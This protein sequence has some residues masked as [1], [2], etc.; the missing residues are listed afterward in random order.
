MR[1]DRADILLVEDSASDLELTLHVLENQQLN[2]RV[3]VARDGEEALAMLFA[4]A[5][6]GDPGLLPRVVLLDL[7][8]P[9]V[10]GLE[11]LAAIRADPRTSSIPVVILTSSNEQ[12]DVAEGYRLRANSYIQKPVDFEAF[13][14]TI[15]QMGI[16][17]INANEPP[18]PP[19]PQSRGGNS[20]RD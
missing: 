17:W 15:R 12:R 6:S 10:D 5:D 2:A 19:E 18:P 14:D 9:K 11:V 8:L 4:R 20:R 13:C 1:S 16:Y 7:K 3:H